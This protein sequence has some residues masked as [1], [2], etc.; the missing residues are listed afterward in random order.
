MTSSPIK[1]SGPRVALYAPEFA[2]DPHRVYR[3]MRERY[4]S[5]VPVDLAPGVSAT[6]VI[7]YRAAVQILH[8]PEHFPADPRM[9]QRT[10]PADCPVRPMLEWRPT[11]SR[12]A[13][14]EHARYRRA[15]VAAIEG[16][17]LHGLHTTVERI[18]IPLIDSFREAGTAE[19]IE[20]YA[21]PLAFQTINVMLGCSPEIGRRAA[22]G[23]TAVFDG[24]N[25]EQGNAMLGEAMMELAALKRATPGNDITTRLLQHP[26]GLDDSEVMQQ[27]IP[28]YGAGVGPLVNLIANTLVLIL[29]DERFAG[30]VLGG[31][32]ST[33]D[34]LDEVLFQDPPL[35]NF[36]FSYPRQPV[37]I[38]TVWLPAHQP[39]VISMAACNNDPEISGGER[40]GNRSH[41]AWGS[42]PHACP[43][44]QAA[45][46]I[47][48]DAVD[49]LLDVLPE[50][51]LAA[52]PEKL[53]WRPGPL[54][55]ALTALPVTFRPSRP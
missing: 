2:A 24:V 53:I 17:D 46:L 43:A 47:A 30:G 34:A 37:L 45:Y 42:G 12:S 38:G 5:L 48:Q 10:V 36:C 1:A 13:G 31:S 15:T 49:Q 9:W 3:E 7:G 14:M 22:A 28:M 8:D 21:F 11:A 20:Q 41:L 29:T 35:A 44:R 23:V 54:H 4:G 51:R 26:V 25:A 50:I 16:L 55:R 6:L 52:S 18:A 27:V 33:R 39:V 32:L 40:T 19:L